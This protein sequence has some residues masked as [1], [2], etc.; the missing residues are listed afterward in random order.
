[1]KLTA[2]IMPFRLDD[3]SRSHCAAGIIMAIPI[4]SFITAIK[5]RP[6]TNST[7]ICT[8]PKPIKICAI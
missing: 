5:I 6:H 3:N 2:L 4:V 7:I 1:M 8:F